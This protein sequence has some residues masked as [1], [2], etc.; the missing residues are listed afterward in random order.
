MDASRSVPLGMH[1]L[2]SRVLL[3]AASMSNAF[4]IYEEM[5][6]DLRPADVAALRADVRTH[7]QALVVAQKK[8]ELVAIDYAEALCLRLE[9]LLLG[10]HLLDAEARASLVGAARYYVSSSDAKP[11]DQSCT[12]L[13]D[14]VAV[15]N[16]VVRQLGRDDLLIEE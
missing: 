14:D 13:D 16:H 8:N 10:A 6:A 9:A 11:D 7:F 3:N 12:G 15:F 1:R 2:E 4:E 5:R